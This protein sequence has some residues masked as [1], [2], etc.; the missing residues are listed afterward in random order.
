VGEK[1]YKYDVI[2]V[3]GGLAGC[4]AACRAKEVLGG[5]GSV[6]M[7]DK[8]Y[9]GFS[10]QS[11]FAAGAYLA[12]DPDKHDLGDWLEEIVS[13]G[14]YL[15][16]QEWCK[17]TL[18]GS[19]EPVRLIQGWAAENKSEAFL[20]NEDGTLMQRQSRGHRRTS[21]LAGHF[22]PIMQLL[23]KKV[24]NSGVEVHDRVMITD[25]LMH[26]GMPEG[27]LGLAH[28]ESK[29][30]L[31]A[32]KAILLAASGSGFK[33]V[34]QGHQAL[35]GDL[36][37]AALE[38]GVVFRNMEQYYSNTTHRDFDIHGMTLFVG[39]GG[40]F[41]NRLGEDFMVHYNP[42]LG[43]RAR[44]PE[45]VLAFCREVQEGRGPITLDLT[46]VSEEDR[47]LCRKA[48][49]GTFLLWD[50]AGVDPFREPMEWIPAQYASLASGGG[51]HVPLSCETNIPY[52][53]AAG[54]ITCLPPHGTY[55]VGG[56]NLAFCAVSGLRA[57]R[58]A[59][60]ASR[61]RRKTH[62]KLQHL[63]SGPVR[64]LLKPLDGDA[65]NPIGMEEVLLR[66]QRLVIPY[67]VGYLKSGAR[68]TE[69][70]READRMEL[71]D[72]PRLRPKDGHALMRA[73][74][75]RSMLR[76]AQV[77]IR[78]SLTRTESR[79]FHF[80]QDFPVTDNV[81]W[82]KWV[83]IHRPNQTRGVGGVE[84][85]TEDVPTPYVRP[86]EDFSRPS[87]MRGAQR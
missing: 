74:E 39:V 67:E 21:H 78:A 51:I 73:V 37:A 48:L 69:A 45:L 85:Y 22:L 55:S 76:V 36:Q 75:C 72:L 26:E 43:S 70:L 86:K 27:L 68:L 33:S 30:H 28:R 82:L 47:I 3:G 81:N 11:P 38:A 61:Q 64:D 87:G 25:L 83:M 15:S 9:A 50:R 35:T 49:P 40:I 80:R 18:L 13:S 57:G 66:I 34:F 63:A 46:R 19:M 7:I 4:L 59:A 56:L 58:N 10:G 17:E 84:T 14:E 65:R 1:I 77:M 42:G 23:R 20:E 79:G 71:E 62:S 44:S 12:F 29:I 8:G 60:Q 54:D 16:D 53:F 5:K 24:V 32:A 41:T 31:Y 2:V 52:L 6:A